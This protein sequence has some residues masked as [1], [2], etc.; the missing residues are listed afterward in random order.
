MPTDFLSEEY[1]VSFRTQLCPDRKRGCTKGDKCRFSHA[2]D[3]IRRRAFYHGSREKIKYCH[4]LCE[5]VALVNGRPHNGCD[6]GSNCPFSHSV[7]ELEYHPLRYKTTLC[8]MFHQTGLCLRPYCPNIHGIAE[9][10]KD[11]RYFM[12]GKHLRNDRVTLPPHLTGITVIESDAE[13]PNHNEN[14]NNPTNTSTRSN[15]N[16]PALIKTSPFT[17]RRPPPP[18]SL[19]P[20]PSTTSNQS[21][22]AKLRS[23]TVST[24]TTKIPAPPRTLPPPSLPHNHQ[25]S[26]TGSNNSSSSFPTKQH[27]ADGAAGRIETRASLEANLRARLGPLADE[28]DAE[29][30]TNGMVTALGHECRSTSGSPPP[31]PPPPTHDPE[32]CI[33]VPPPPPQ[34]QQRPHQQ[35][36]R[37]TVVAEKALMHADRLADLVHSEEFLEVSAD[38]VKQA[39]CTEVFK[40]V[41]EVCLTVMEAGED[42]SDLMHLLIDMSDPEVHSLAHSLHTTLAHTFGYVPNTP[43]PLTT[44]T[45]TTH[46]PTTHQ[47]QQG[48]PPSPPTYQEYHLFGDAV[49]PNRSLTLT[50]RTI[51]GPAFTLG[52]SEREGE[53]E[54]QGGRQNGNGDRAGSQ[55]HRDGS[56]L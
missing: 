18:L 47:Q 42:A 1:L 20:S 3:W 54:G 39:V 35:R 38:A 24:N 16:D 29:E 51:G 45:T 37:S 40:K 43:P 4:Q 49:T 19:S 41:A 8:P 15:T 9:E 13:L 33:K 7:E 27:P 11:K 53:G 31:P 21:D 46:T 10:R 22:L 2:T 5:F 52:G 25:K 26:S 32:D 55:G 23:P 6:R 56:F 30:M 44:S 14:A 28:K 50:T 12:I 36:D 48:S 17:D 34:Q